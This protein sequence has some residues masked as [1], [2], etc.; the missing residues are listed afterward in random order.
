MG[1]HITEASLLER[2]FALSRDDMQEQ[3][4]TEAQVLRMA[5]EGLT[6]PNGDNGLLLVPILE[7]RVLIQWV[8]LVRARAQQTDAL[9]EHALSERSQARLLQRKKRMLAEVEGILGNLWSYADQAHKAMDTVEDKDAMQFVIELVRELCLQVLGG[10]VMLDQRVQEVAWKLVFEDH[11]LAA[12]KM[13]WTGDIRHLPAPP[14]LIRSSRH[15]RQLVA[16]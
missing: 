12:L 6:V 15:S 9:A 2:A 11:S 14:C 3:L 10:L 7:R 8:T 16:A 13:W 4:L 1:M 5:T